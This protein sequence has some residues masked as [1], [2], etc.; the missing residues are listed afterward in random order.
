MS[1]GEQTNLA[2]EQIDNGRYE[3]QDILVAARGSDE[4]LAMMAVRAEDSTTDR[5]VF[6]KVIDPTVG[7]NASARIRREAEVLSYLNHPHVPDLYAADPDAETPYIVTQ[8]M[9]GIEL[10]RLHKGERY[11]TRLAAAL[12]V[13]A[14]EVLDYVHEQG[15]IHRD[16]KHANLLAA[17]GNEINVIDFDIAQIRDQAAARKIAGDDEPYHHLKVEPELSGVT[18]GTPEYMSPE[19][20]LGRYVGPASD[21]YSMGVL[22]Y[23]MTTATAPGADRVTMPIYRA[24][25]S[26]EIRVSTQNPNAVNDFQLVLARATKEKPEDRY[27]SAGEMKEALEASIY[28]RKNGHTGGRALKIDRFIERLKIRR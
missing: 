1:T 28:S 19:Q 5:E 16:I 15:V 12:G 18:A 8:W 14:L 3:V 25:G 26:G 2:P 24:R 17:S 11:P 9:P 4:K 20:Q 27:E 7:K 10:P 22:L 13:A 21:L 6:L 23:M